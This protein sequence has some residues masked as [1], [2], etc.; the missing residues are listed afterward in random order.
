MVKQAKPVKY[1]FVWSQGGIETVAYSGT[2]AEML[3]WLDRKEKSHKRIGFTVKRKGD[4]IYA[5]KKFPHM[6]K[7][8]W[9]FIRKA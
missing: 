5:W 8:R 4:L 1:E 7:K 2:Y 9:I 6:I 3:T